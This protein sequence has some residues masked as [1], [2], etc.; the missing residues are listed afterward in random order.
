MLSFLIAGILITACTEE[1]K[2]MIFNG[3]DLNNWTIF[4]VDSSADPTEVFQVKDGIMHVS[5]IPNGYI[6]TKDE[7]S[8]YKLHVE[9]RWV[10]EPKNSG[11][12]CHVQGEDMVWPHAIECQLMNQHAGDIVLMREGAGVTVNDT[13]YIVKPGERPYQSIGRIEESSENPAGEWNTYDITC[14]GTNIELIV[15]GV[16]QNVGTDLTLTSGSIALQS[17]GGPIEFRNVY[18]IPLK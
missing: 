17:E 14:D 15:N 13:A 6:R 1:K 2:V 3:E 12:L 7:Y 10:E 11:V 8:H 5:G 16:L 9:W 18:L 4:L